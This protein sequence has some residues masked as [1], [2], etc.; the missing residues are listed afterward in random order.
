MTFG[1]S[2]A[3]PVDGSATT[4]DGLHGRSSIWHALNECSGGRL[5]SG[6]IAEMR[7]LP[8]CLRQP[9]IRND[10]SQAGAKCPATL[11]RTFVSNTCSRIISGAH[12]VQ[13]VAMSVSVSVCR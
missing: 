9:A 8:H 3:H 2:A 4:H 5:C 11:S 13:P 10:R 7:A 1:H 12:S 6:L